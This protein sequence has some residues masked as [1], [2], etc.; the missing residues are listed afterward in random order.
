M[1]GAGLMTNDKI[2]EDLLALLALIDEY[3]STVCV[4]T[5]EHRKPGE[6]HCLNISQLLKISTTGV[7][8]RLRKLVMMGYLNRDRVERDDGKVMGQYTLSKEGLKLL[9]AGKAT[10]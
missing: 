1:E 3:G 2:P 8:N 6:L 10:V 4:G 9:A 5:C 7:K